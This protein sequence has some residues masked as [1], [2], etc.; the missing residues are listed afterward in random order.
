MKKRRLWL[1]GLLFSLPVIGYLYERWAANRARNNL[2]PPR[3]LVKV[4]AIRLHGH[5]MGTEHSDLTVVLE[6]GAGG[7]SPEWRDIQKEVA[8]FARVV[9]YDHWSLRRFERW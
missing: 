2:K 8:K 3:K 5:E 6:S 7:F 4:G 1:I 9:S